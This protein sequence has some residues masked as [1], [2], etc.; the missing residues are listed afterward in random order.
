MQITV[1]SVPLSGRKNVR[2]VKHGR[3]ASAWQ[4]ITF[5]AFSRNTHKTSRGVIEVR[6]IV[7]LVEP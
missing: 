3:I 5:L 1:Y 2:A 4:L 6:V 7:I